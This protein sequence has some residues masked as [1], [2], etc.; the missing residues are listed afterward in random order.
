MYDTRDFA[1]L[2]SRVFLGN[3]ML[4]IKVSCQS[5]RGRGV[6][7]GIG[8]IEK[9]C[10]GCGGSGRV[11]KEAVAT[12]VAS[13]EST[14]ASKSKQAAPKKSRSKKVE[15]IPASQAFEEMGVPADVI[16]A[17]IQPKAP[18]FSGYTDEFMEA[19]F[20]EV[21]MESMAWR[22]K[23]S[24]VKELFEFS[25]ITRQLEEKITKVARAGIRE[26]YA[27]Q[28]PRA[29]RTIDMQ[30]YQDQVAESDVQY[31][32]YKAHEKAKLEAARSK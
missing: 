31:L 32:S 22:Q 8:G 4:E 3:K 17:A 27:L 16:E 29:P 26:A 7:A 24:H 20:D 25:P 13:S 28:Q 11:L 19:I 2:E 9:E 12:D 21:R 10:N 6:F 30:A 5:C 1:I 18:I 14:E 23:Y 15:S